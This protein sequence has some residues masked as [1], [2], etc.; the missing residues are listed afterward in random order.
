[1]PVYNKLANIY[2]YVMRNIR[3][4]EWADYINSV[5]ATYVSQ[6]S[7]VLELAGGNGSF[8]NHFVRYF[9]NLIVTD[10]SRNML[11]NSKNKS[12]K[13][14]CCDM[15]RLPFKKKF[16]LIF[17]TFD[18]INYLTDEKSLLN[19]FIEVKKILSDEGIFTF[20]VSLEKNSYRHMKN[21]LREGTYK[22]ISYSQKSIY[23]KENKIHKNIFEI[24]NKKGE[25]TR[26][27]HKQKIYPF[28]TYFEML[29]KTNLYA[30]ECFDAFSF[31][32]GSADSERVQF[33]I[34][35]IKDNASN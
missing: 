30:A 13:R 21:H 33:V 4:D 25:I 32:N 17:S 28:E 5:S 8:A 15:T 19:L 24:K 35:K 3:Y 34:K 16:D 29:D 26:E 6:K 20:D 9:P 14:V 22:G 31:I 27:I 7:Q 18:S 11:L 2:D 12:I 23:D 1:M 10:I